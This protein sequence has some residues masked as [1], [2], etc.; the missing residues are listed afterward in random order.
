MRECG[1]Q[2]AI[3]L[4]QPDIRVK[5]IITHAWPS[6]EWPG[7][8]MAYKSFFSAFGIVPLSFTVLITG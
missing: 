4:L 3:V 2:T 6:G 5:Q 7:E 8:I 1:Y